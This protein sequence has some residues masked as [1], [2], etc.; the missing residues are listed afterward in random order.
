MILF[1]KESSHITFNKQMDKGIQTKLSVGIHIIQHFN[2]SIFT[3]TANEYGSKCRLLASLTT[4]NQCQPWKNVYLYQPYTETVNRCQTLLL[5]LHFE[6]LINILEIIFFFYLMSCLVRRTQ[7]PPPPSTGGNSLGD[8]CQR[9][10]TSWV[11]KDL[12][13]NLMLP[14][15]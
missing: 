15:F 7:Q 11:E 4:T 6:N 3:Y 14:L 5:Y 12:D 2:T 1:H 9:L 8:A 13:H 10:R